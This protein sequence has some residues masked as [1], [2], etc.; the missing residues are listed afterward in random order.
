[1]ARHNITKATHERLAA[2]F[3]DL[4]TRARFAVADKIERAREMGDLSENGDYHAAKDE[5][6][7]MEGRIRQLED[8]LEDHEIVAPGVEGIVSAGAVVSF[9]YHGDSDDDAE[10]YLIG[11]ME[12]RR[13]G[14]ELMSPKA[15]L[16]GALMGRSIG[17]TVEYEAPNGNKLS[18]RILSVEHYA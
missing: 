7:H 9:V 4:T 8:I 2:E 12:E 5:Q 11:H 6:G 1:M 3:F 14:I 17:E 13:E 15:P 16:G 10:T 18:V